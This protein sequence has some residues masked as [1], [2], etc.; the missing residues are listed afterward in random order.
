MNLDPELRVCNPPFFLA[1]AQ[2]PEGIRVLARSK[3]RPR[4][5]VGFRSGLSPRRNF[6]QRIRRNHPELAVRSAFLVSRLP[7]LFLN[8]KALSV[9]LSP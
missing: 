4:G 1:I 7:P 3:S 5:G 2:I 9:R 8:P 6:S